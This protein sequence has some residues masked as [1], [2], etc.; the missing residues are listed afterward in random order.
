[1]LVADIDVVESELAVKELN[2]PFVAVSPA[3]DIIDVLMLVEV[4]GPVVTVLAVSDAAVNVSA[5]GQTD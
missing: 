3:A 1:M 2:W 4:I 5:M